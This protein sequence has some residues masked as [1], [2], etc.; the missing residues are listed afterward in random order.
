MGVSKAAPIF[1]D[2]RI[3]LF[4]FCSNFLAECTLRIGT[5]QTDSAPCSPPATVLQPGSGWSHSLSLSSQA[6]AAAGKEIGKP[7]R[8]W[9]RWGVRSRRS[10]PCKNIG[11]SGGSC[12]P[13]GEAKAHHPRGRRAIETAPLPGRNPHPAK[14]GG[15]DTGGLRAFPQSH[16]HSQRAGFATAS[17]P[18]KSSARPAGPLRSCPAGD[19]GQRSGNTPKPATRTAPASAPAGPPAFVGR[20]NPGGDSESGFSPAGHWAD[21][22]L[23]A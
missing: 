8:S 10:S 3:S 15:C 7:P 1:Q 5:L 21:L 2:I 18:P 11:P 16:T 4:Y 23:P 12:L 14:P 20:K 22:P 6:A 13:G 19:P 17:S 9:P